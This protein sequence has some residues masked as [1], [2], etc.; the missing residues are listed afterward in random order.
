[1]SK[2]VGIKNRLAFAQKTC[3]FEKI[4]PNK[5][6]FLCNLL[7]T[8]FSLEIFI[9]MNKEQKKEKMIF[10]IKSNP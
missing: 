7:I 5:T 3:S 4:A 6:S 9:V 2:R 10:D 1:M 8:Q